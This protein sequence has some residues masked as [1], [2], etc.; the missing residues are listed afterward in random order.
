MLALHWRHLHK[1]VSQT[2]GILGMI[3]GNLAFMSHVLLDLSLYFVTCCHTCL[4]SL[5]VISLGS[6]YGTITFTMVRLGYKYNESINKTRILIW[7]LR[8]KTEDPLC[9]LHEKAWQFVSMGSEGCLHTM[10]LHCRRC[11]AIVAC[12]LHRETR[13]IVPPPNNAA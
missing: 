7:E 4:P 13:A 10:L 6:I 1:I 2:C 12:N 9:T 11:C 3:R 5:G 8:T